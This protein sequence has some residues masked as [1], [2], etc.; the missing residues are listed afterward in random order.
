M[1]VQ[2]ETTTKAGISFSKKSLGLRLGNV[3]FRFEN[4]K[5]KLFC[6][7]SQQPLALKEVKNWVW[8]VT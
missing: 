7:R 8:G 1:I 4:E 5:R 3:N 2:K 6:L